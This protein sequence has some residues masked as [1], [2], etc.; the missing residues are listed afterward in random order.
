VA[1]IGFALLFELA[2]SSGSLSGA[3][4]GF[5][6]LAGGGFAASLSVRG[7]AWDGFEAGPAAIFCGGGFLSDWHVWYEASSGQTDASALCVIS[8][9]LQIEG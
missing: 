9:T 5:A 3:F 8:A 2:G 1:G 6:V 4:C 7:F